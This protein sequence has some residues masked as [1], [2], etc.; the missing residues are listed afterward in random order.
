MSAVN[1]TN[2]HAGEQKKSHSNKIVNYIGSLAKIILFIIFM[3]YL[4]SD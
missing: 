2:T 1:I 3:N 4:Y